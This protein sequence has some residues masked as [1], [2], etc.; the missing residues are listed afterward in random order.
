MRRLERIWT[1]F[2]DS[3]GGVWFIP[4]PDPGADL[5]FQDPADTEIDDADADDL[6]YASLHSAGRYNRAGINDAEIDEWAVAQRR[7][8]D[9]LEWAELLE[10]IR[11]KEQEEVWRILLVN[12]YG[13]RVRRTGVFNLLDTYYAKSLQLATDQLKRVWVEP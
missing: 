12:P 3:Q 6:A 13:V 10:Q 4:E 9:P 5:V 1:Q 8:L 2:I 7:A 11:R